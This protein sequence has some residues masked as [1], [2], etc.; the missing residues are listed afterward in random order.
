MADLFDYLEWRGDLTFDQAPFCKVDAVILAQII[1]IDY[2]GLVTEKFKDCIDLPSLWD[3]L[4]SAGDFKERCDMGPMVNARTPELLEKASKS[5]R[6]SSVKACAYQ[7]IFD[8]NQNQ[9]FAAITYRI[10][11]KLSVI[12][13]RG[14]DDTVT[15]WRENFNLGY[16]A[17]I[18]SHLSALSYCANAC[19]FLKSKIILAGHSKGGNIALH[20]AVFSESKNRKK[21]SAVYNFDGPGFSNEFYEKPEFLEIKDRLTVCYPEQSIVGMIFHRPRHF[22]VIKS[23]KFAVYQ[24][25]PFNWKVK[26]FDFERAEDVCRESKLFH[27]SLNNWIENMSYDEKKKFINSLFSVINAS[28]YDHFAEIT[29]N[30]VPASAKM[31]KCLGSM[32]KDLRDAI[33]NSIRELSNV[34]RA[35]IPLLRLLS[36]S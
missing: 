5:R 30:V 23:E 20:T 33:F 15:G 24:H 16:M 12:A 10:K 8:K 34:V 32:D 14:T 31:I 4:K 1:Y 35:E 9:Q 6:F 22:E 27:K 7:N 13:F 18:P 19:R 3:K 28:G 21:I 36:R 25:D 29:K 2:K 26:A 11:E 17:E